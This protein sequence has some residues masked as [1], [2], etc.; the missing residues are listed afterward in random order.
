[1]NGPSLL[2][3]VIDH[4]DAVTRIALAKAV[5]EHGFPEDRVE[6]TFDP[7]VDLS[8]A[9]NVRW[10]GGKFLHYQEGDVYVCPP[11]LPVRGGYI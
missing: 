7:W 5:K 3:R 8:R 9:L 6:N 4:G 2:A 1:M 11:N 10:D